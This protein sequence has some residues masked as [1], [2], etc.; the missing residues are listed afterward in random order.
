MQGLLAYMC[1]Q[2]FA[3]SAPADIMTPSA[4]VWVLKHKGESQIL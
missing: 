1:F 2:M 4:P 3:L